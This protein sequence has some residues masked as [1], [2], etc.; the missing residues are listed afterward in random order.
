MIDLRPHHGMCLFFFQGKGY[1]DAFTENMTKIKRALDA[2]PL[3][4]LTNEAD[5]ICS[6]CPN[7]QNEICISLEKVNRYDSSVLELCSLEAGSVLSFQDLQQRIRRNI[8][9][10]GKRPQIC[11]DCQWNELCRYSPLT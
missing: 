9:E 10:A 3:V 4:R 11:G 8:L 5:A 2:N 1:S 6:A 7:N